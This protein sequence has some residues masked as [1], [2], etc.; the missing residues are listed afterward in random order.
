ME[1]FRREVSTTQSKY[2]ALLEKKNI[3]QQCSYNLPLEME[4]FLKKN[5]IIERNNLSEPSTNFSYKVKDDVTILLSPNI[6]AIIGDEYKGRTNKVIFT[7]TE[8]N[9]G[10]SKKI[11]LKRKDFYNRGTE[12]E[13]F[14]KLYDN[15]V[16]GINF[17]TI[18][19]LENR[20]IIFDLELTENV[21]EHD[22]VEDEG[23]IDIESLTGGENIIYYGTPGCGKSYLVD[24]KYDI[25]G[26]KVYR[27]VFHPEYSNSDFVGQ[28]MPEIDPEDN[29]T[30]LYNFREG[31]FTIALKY[32]FDNPSVNT[33]LIIEE[34]NRGNASAIFGEIFQLLDRDENGSSIYKIK[35][36]YMA[37]SLGK[38][39]DYDI[40]I[41]SNLTLV[42]T[43]NTSDQNV[44]TLDTA[45]KRRWILK[46]I[47]N[48]FKDIENY[49][50]LL[51]SQQEDLKYKYELSKKYIPGSSCTWKAFVEKINARISEKG[52]GYFVQSEDKEIG[53][54]FVSHSYLSDTPNNNDIELIRNFG[55]KVLM[56][57][58]NDVVKTNPEKLFN[59]TDSSDNPIL[60]LDN[61]LDEF[62][63]IPGNDTLNIFSGEL[64]SQN[65]TE[66]LSTDSTSDG[67][68]AN[69]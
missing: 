21:F 9:G 43:M 63:K 1:K 34:I 35:N 33:I 37:K 65:D 45:F 36:K 64:F 25:E 14:V 56:Y 48:T 41:P 62:E 51:A 17:V 7:H 5:N 61:L 69:E 44:Y 4:D 52:K 55:E 23:V 60:S 67:D 38:E 31:I 8:G 15:N 50:L 10:S 30:I 3:T 54:F 13:W 39:E 16:E 68:G 32:A 29:K 18:V 26:N 46:K 12:Y 20:E 6:Y 53:V 42:G 47:R 2:K 19:D 49:S 57:L 66:S 22:G 58:W 59:L 24:K 28:I 40:S 27:T 11:Q